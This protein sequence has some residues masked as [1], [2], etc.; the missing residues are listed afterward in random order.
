[1]RAFEVLDLPVE[2]PDARRLDQVRGEV[3]LDG[4]A[5]RY[6]ADEATVRIDGHDVRILTLDPWCEAIGLVTQE[7][8]LFDDTLGANLRFAAPGASD[9]DLVELAAGHTTI[10]IAHRLSTDRRADE[11]VM[12]GKG[13]IVEQGRHDEL[14][15]RG[16]RHARLAVELIT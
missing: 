11:I 2:R 4:A 13:R 14:L 1:M 9:A 3:R 12:L 7:T 10:A 16:G 15:A 8:Y 5:F 6:D